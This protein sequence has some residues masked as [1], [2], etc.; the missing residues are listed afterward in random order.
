ML[1]MQ[2]EDKGKEKREAKRKTLKAQK[3]GRQEEVGKK[4]E[5]IKKRDI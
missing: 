4:I 5:Y 1:D 2:W 3:N